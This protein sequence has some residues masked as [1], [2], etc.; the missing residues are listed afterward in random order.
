[1]K[2]EEIKR[3][4]F[5]DR[6]H[7]AITYK[8]MIMVFAAW[9]VFLVLLYGVQILREVSLKKKI[10]AAKDYVVQL[11]NE[12][13]Q[14]LLQIQKASRKNVGL[15][16]QQGL[17]DIIRN[18]PRWSKIVSVLTKSLPPQV[19]LDA[20][21]VDKDEEGI[22]K[23]KIVGKA[24][25]QRALTSFIMGVESSGIFSGTAL[26][27]SKMASGE[28]DLLDYEIITHPLVFGL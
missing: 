4:N 7:G 28:K 27:S 3:M 1:M 18:R 13:D 26:V 20:V 15:T 9:C 5:L 23:M 21:S 11:D 10:S 14:H 12:K 19:W 22:Y 2:E 16:V 24:K 17:S 8:T 6:G 25:S